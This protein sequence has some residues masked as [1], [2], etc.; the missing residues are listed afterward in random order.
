MGWAGNGK[1]ERVVWNTTRAVGSIIS[2][3]DLSEANTMVIDLHAGLL[4]IFLR[5]GNAT[6]LWRK[7][8]QCRGRLSAQVEGCAEVKK[9]PPNYAADL[10]LSNHRSDSGTCSCAVFVF[11]AGVLLSRLQA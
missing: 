4:M 10:I 7:V 9:L 11:T 1:R 8:I 6:G 2:Y 5:T 3:S